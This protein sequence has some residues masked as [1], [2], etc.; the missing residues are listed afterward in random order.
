MELKICFISNRQTKGQD[1]TADGY[2]RSLAGQNVPYINSL[3][4][5]EALTHH[6]VSFLFLPKQSIGSAI[7]QTTGLYDGCLGALQ[8]GDAD[9]ASAITP[10]PITATNLTQ[11]PPLVRYESWLASSYKPSAR[12]I[13]PDLMDYLSLIPMRYYVS[14]L[15]ILLT[16]ISLKHWRSGNPKRMSARTGIH[17][18]NRSAWLVLSQLLGN[19]QTCRGLRRQTLLYLLLIITSFSYRIQSY[20]VMKTE[21][22]ITTPAVK[23]RTLDQMFENK[24]TFAITSRV[25]FEIFKNSPNEDIRRM[26]Q[27]SL[28]KGMKNILFPFDHT[29]TV[30]TVRR[31]TDGLLNQK[32]ALVREN[33][34]IL[35]LV[36]CV[37]T[38]RH[39]IS[40]GNHVM[41]VNRLRNS[42]H[43][44]AGIAVSQH[45]WNKQPSLARL[46]IRAIRI[47]ASESM[48]LQKT[49][50]KMIKSSLTK[51]TLDNGTRNCIRRIGEPKPKIQPFTPNVRN[52]RNLIL[53][54]G[55]VNLIATLCCAVEKCMKLRKK[56]VTRKTHPLWTIR[57]LRP[58]PAAPRR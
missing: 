26:F 10:F 50:A 56:R 1:F 30:D 33:A 53:I 37:L 19:Y 44:L 45:L 6:N 41:I 40:T 43:P 16:L 48:L 52:L 11:G 39:N 22:V 46:L 29:L 4:G 32:H 58:L 51:K 14:V 12:R 24:M 17:I 25:E 42:P 15:M 38:Q 9:V 20:L 34:K 36:L 21:Q 2:A 31:F 28:A 47:S 57:S 3:L 35:L 8:A 23:I 55:I 27:L 13:S 5:L 54:C 49:H 7:N 18:L